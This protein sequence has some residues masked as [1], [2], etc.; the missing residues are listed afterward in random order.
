MARTLGMGLGVMEKGGRLGL[1]SR[2]ASMA[3]PRAAAVGQ[4]ESPA[5]AV[6]RP[7]VLAVAA[8]P[9]LARQY[10]RACSGGERRGGSGGVRKGRE[11]IRRRLSKASGWGWLW[12]AAAG[13]YEAGGRLEAEEREQGGPIP[14]LGGLADCHLTPAGQD[15]V[16]GL[17]TRERQHEEFNQ[18][19]HE[20]LVC[21]EVRASRGLGSSA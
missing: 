21:E 14:G 13:T 6:R 9:T 2:G 4:W 1:R 19:A 15:R 5:A 17:C 10:C 18:S 12:E 16:L 11:V 8:R 3:C 7:G 20:A